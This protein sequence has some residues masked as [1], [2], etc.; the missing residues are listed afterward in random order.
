MEDGSPKLEDG[1]VIIIK[2]EIPKSEKTE[3]FPSFRGVAKFSER[4]F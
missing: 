3:I 1:E 2:Y 4:K